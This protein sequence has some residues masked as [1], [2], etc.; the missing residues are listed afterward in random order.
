MRLPSNFIMFKYSEVGIKHWLFS[1]MPIF[2]I[3]QYFTEPKLNNH[4]LSTSCFIRPFGVMCWFDLV[5]LTPG[6][7]LT[8][9]YFDSGPSAAKR[10]CRRSIAWVD[11]E[12]NL[13]PFSIRAEKIDESIES[14][15]WFARFS[16]EGRLHGVAVIQEIEEGAHRQ[17]YSVLDLFY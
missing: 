7:S 15:F 1:V 5:V 11:L 16:R 9:N 12:V 10:E 4:N 2:P 13:D 8:P 6:F 3:F 14:P 17:S